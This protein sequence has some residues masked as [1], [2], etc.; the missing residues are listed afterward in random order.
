MPDD[1]TP[2]IGDGINAG[3]A[4]T[5]M[6]RITLPVFSRDDPELWFLA[7][8]QIFEANQILT[9]N[10]RFSYLLQN[11]TASDLANIK[12][13]LSTQATDRFTQAKNRLVKLHGVSQEEKMNRILSGTNIDTSQKPSIILAGL[14]EALGPNPSQADCKI[15]RSIWLQKLPART[16]EFLVIY[17]DDPADKQAVVADR[18]FEQYE[19]PSVPTGTSILSTSV[20]AVASGNSIGTSQVDLLLSMLQNL[21]VQIAEIRADRD[22]R[23]SHTPSRNRSRNSSPDNYRLRNSSPHPRSRSRSRYSD[24]FN[25]GQCWYHAKF[26]ENARKCMQGCSKHSQFTSQSANS[27][28]A[29]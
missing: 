1:K 20:N 23:W 27:G 7:A 17:Q 4:A 2:L 10:E 12:D 18:L 13:I 8:E 26:G 9:E 25:D 3:N 24:W 6:V 16:R 29:N 21:T 15:L 28:N 11:L 5:R 19:K 22:H 14:K